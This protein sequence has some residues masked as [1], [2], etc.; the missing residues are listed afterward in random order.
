MSWVTCEPKSRMRI[1]SITSRASRLAPRAS[2]N[3]VIR[4]FLRDLHVVDVRLAHAGG[5]DLHEL[6]LAAHLFDRAASGVAHARA[7]AAHQLLDDRGRGPLVGDAALD[8]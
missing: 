4:R 2:L 3:V 6:G 8:A 5:C 7:H 1:L